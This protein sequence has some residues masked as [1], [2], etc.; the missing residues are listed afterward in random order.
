MFDVINKF[1]EKFVI[2]LIN[3]RN[4]EKADEEYFKKILE[5]R[6]EKV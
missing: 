6:K 2:N 5:L 4:Q 1:L 3:K